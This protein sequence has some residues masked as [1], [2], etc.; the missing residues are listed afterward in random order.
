MRTEYAIDL[1]FQD[2]YPK[3]GKILN[4]YENDKVRLISS[5]NRP[6]TAAKLNNML[7]YC[8]AVWVINDGRDG[9][10]HATIYTNAKLN[11]IKLYLPEIITLFAEL[12]E[13]SPMYFNLYVN[14]Y[15]EFEQNRTY[16]VFCIE[17]K[18]Y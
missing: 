15:N 5:S 1:A 14:Y 16:K 18:E 12:K 3:L 8:Q 6:A 17:L 7:E 2:D 9:N 11:D 4:I 10:N 13:C